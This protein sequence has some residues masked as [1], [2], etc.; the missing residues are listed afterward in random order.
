MLYNQNIKT[1][2]SLDATNVQHK[3]WRPHS[4]LYLLVFYVRHFRIDCFFRFHQGV[5]KDRVN[6]IQNQ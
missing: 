5:L 4:T 2:L 6:P 1:L 3:L